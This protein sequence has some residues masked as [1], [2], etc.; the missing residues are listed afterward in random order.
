MELVLDANILFAAI[1]RDRDTR[2]L[3]FS[4]FVMLYTSDTILRELDAH[5]PEISRKIH[6]TNDEFDSLMAQIFSVIKIVS[7][8][9]TELSMDEA[10]RICPDPDDIPYFA[11]ALHLKI[12]IWSQDKDLKK[13]K[14]IKVYS[15]EELVHELS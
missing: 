4:E 9:E 7:L 10:R 8:K 13:Q 14:F 11:L 2:K 15:T 6:L 3:L 1:I 12:P 5:K